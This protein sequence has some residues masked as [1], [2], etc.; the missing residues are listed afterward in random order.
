MY[1]LNVQTLII[2]DH[3]EA[4]Q[5]DELLTY[6]F[7]SF[8]TVFQSYHFSQDDVRVIKGCLQWSPVYN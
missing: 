6:S 2:L 7:T 4:D 3:E 1:R 5:M 8:S